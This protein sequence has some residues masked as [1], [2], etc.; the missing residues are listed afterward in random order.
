VLTCA[1]SAAAITPNDPGWSDGW[2]QQLVEMPKAWD[3]TTGS[4]DVVIA[5]VDTGIAGNLPDLQGALVQGWDFVQNDPIPQDTGRLPH[6]TLTATELVARGNNGVG[7]AGYC[8]RCKVMPL[9]ASDTGDSFDGVITARA[10][11]YAVAHGARIISMGF[12]DEGT[13]VA[14]PDIAGAIASAAARNVLVIASAGNSG[15]S[16]LTHP[17]ADPGAYS[18]AATDP[19]DNLWPWSTFGSWVSLAAP[20]CQLMEY[21]DGTSRL[22]CGTSA[23]TPAVAGIAALMLSV[24]PGLTPPQVISAL[25]ATAVPIAGNGGGRVDA[26]RALLAVGAKAPPPPPPPPPPSVP[27]PPRPPRSS[28]AVSKMATRVQRGVLRRHRFTWIDV[29]AGRVTATLRSVKAKSC[30][31][32]LQSSTDAWLSAA[33]RRDAVSVA[34]KVPAGRYKVDVWCSTA[35]PRRFALALRAIFA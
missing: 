6:G 1:S 3:L 13:A 8:W 31:V 21:P 5:V 34:A 24:N 26:Y 20:G 16:N 10:I 25:R 30:T 14:N 29:K 23:A 22:L 32:G 12:N 33:H 17:A 4:P 35:Q 15:G 19:W 28:P 2:G 27:A 18:V 7:I 9:R 11:Y